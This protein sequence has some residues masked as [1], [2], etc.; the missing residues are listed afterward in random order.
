M[1][2]SPDLIDLHVAARLRMR[3]MMRGVSQEALAARIGVTFQQIQKYEKGHN[4]IGASRLFQL[5]SALEAPM[6]YFFE[7]L[8]ESG[9]RQQA[10]EDADV[11]ATAMLSTAEGVQMH[12]AFSRIRSAA[13][14]RR[15]ID[16]L[17][18][19]VEGEAAET[20]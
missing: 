4:R 14:R 20:E 18:T 1:S 11:A 10:H 17:A 16:L 3:R 5:A 8:P 13:T 19:I 2:R 9:V 15:V 6:D 12:L 7:G